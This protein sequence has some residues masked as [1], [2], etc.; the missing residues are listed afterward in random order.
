MNVHVPLLKSNFVILFICSIT[1][2]RSDNLSKESILKLIWK[3]FSNNQGNDLK[4]LIDI[5]S[6]LDKTNQAG[7]YHRIFCACQSKLLSHYLVQKVHN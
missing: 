7:I 5:K 2:K 4:T 1:V 6:V 3:F